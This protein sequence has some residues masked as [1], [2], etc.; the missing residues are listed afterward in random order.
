MSRSNQSQIWASPVAEGVRFRIGSATAFAVRKDNKDVALRIRREYHPAREA[1]ERIP[2][3]RGIVR[4]AGG[5]ADFLDGVLESAELHPQQIARG[6]RFEQRFAEL[7]RVNPVSFIAA[8]SAIVAIVLLVGLLLVAP[9]AVDRFLLPQFELT[10]PAINAVTCAVRV[11][12]ALICVALIPRLRVLN[13]LCMYRGAINKVL[14]TPAYKGGRVSQ[15]AAGQASHLTRRSDSA[16]AVTVLL[17][18]MIAFALVRTFT[19]PVQ[20]LVRL[21]IVLIIAAVIN[22]PIQLLEKARPGTFAAALL[23]PQL[24]LERLLVRRP[25]PQMVEVAVLAYNA[26]RENDR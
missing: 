23:G 16:F 7:F 20:L 2:F 13:R 22:E 21:L 24:L 25:H 9:W 8:G 18:S 11:L 5:A 17:L 12:G 4:L 14:N 6:R 19:L 26:A 1:M 15:E 10:R 3:V